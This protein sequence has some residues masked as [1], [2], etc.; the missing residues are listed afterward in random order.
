MWPIIWGDNQPG[1]C[2]PLLGQ[3]S[4]TPALSG[5]KVTLPSVTL[6]LAY[7]TSS[8]FWGTGYFAESTFLGLFCQNN[9]QKQKAFYFI[10]ATKSDSNPARLHG[11]PT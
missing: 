8:T 11:K 6:K 2:L 9:P 5:R 3:R 4:E 10:S 1:K 7:I